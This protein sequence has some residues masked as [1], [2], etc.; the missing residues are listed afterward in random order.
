MIGL[1]LLWLPLAA[2]VLS[3]AD[4]TPA[5][6]QTPS[7]PAATLSNDPFGE[8]VMQSKSLS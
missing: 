7:P 5:P 3:A 4:P 6:A 8:E 2:L 1:R